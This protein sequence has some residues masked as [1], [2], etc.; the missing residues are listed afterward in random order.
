MCL[1]INNGNSTNYSYVYPYEN[2]KIKFTEF[3]DLYFGYLFYGFLDEIAIFNRALSPEEIKYHYENP[4]SFDYE[5]DIPPI[6]SISNI[7]S[8]EITY[9]SAKITWDTD[10]P[11]T[12][13]VRYGTTTS[14]TDIKSNSSLVTS[15][16]IILTN[17]LPYQ[18]YYYE[19]ESIYDGN[20]ITDNNNGIYYMFITKQVIHVDSITMS[21]EE[22]PGNKYKITTNVT[23]VNNTNKPV[24]GA[25]VTI[26]LMLPDGTNNSFEGT[27]LNNGIAT[28]IPKTKYPQTGN[29]TSTVTN[30]EKAGFGYEP[31]YNLMTF[32]KLEIPTIP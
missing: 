13:L 21:Y 1:Y 2:K 11:S 10:K 24:N 15:H 18:T 26:E 17:L 3:D 31:S 28:I 20:T 4:G 23:I 25:K 22:V 19:V 16:S 12:S 7:I 29:Y 9:N 14:P 27:T 30:V 5:P 8:S 6:L 32:Y